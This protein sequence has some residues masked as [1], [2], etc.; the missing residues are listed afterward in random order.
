MLIAAIAMIL[1]VVT[2]NF[3]NV[4]VKHSADLDNM[5]GIGKWKGTV[6]GI[7]QVPSPQL[8]SIVMNATNTTKSD[9]I[10]AL[11]ETKN[12]IASAIKILSKP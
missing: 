6:E 1:I 10:W 2:F 5:E 4:F 7:E 11:T 12:D 9:A 3:T 8:V